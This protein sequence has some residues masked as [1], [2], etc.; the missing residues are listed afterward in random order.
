M[1][2]VGGMI[3]TSLWITVVV[4]MTAQVF[5]DAGGITGLYRGPVL[6]VCPVLRHL[7]VRHEPE[8]RGHRPCRARRFDPDQS[9]VGDLAGPFFM[10]A[11]GFSEDTMSSETPGEGNSAGRVAIAG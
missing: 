1:N 3:T 11:L 9:G 5:R 4:W 10:N 8:A 7:Q 6:A 2:V